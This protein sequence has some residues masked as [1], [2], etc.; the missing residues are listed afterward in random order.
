M[1]AKLRI[2]TKVHEAK[3]SSPP[4][5]FTLQLFKIF[6][7]KDKRATRGRLAA[8]EQ[9]QQLFKRPIQKSFV[10]FPTLSDKTK[11]EKKSPTLSNK[12]SFNL[13]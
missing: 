6:G 9:H 7:L 12:N 1:T 10:K 2:I 13:L 3:A 11:T 8:F 5:F 4:L